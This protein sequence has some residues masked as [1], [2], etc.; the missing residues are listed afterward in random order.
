MTTTGHSDLAAL[1]TKAATGSATQPMLTGM[2]EPGGNV[3]FGE[4]RILTWNASTFN[5][6]IAFRGG[7]LSNLPVLSGPDAL[8]YKPD[9]TVAI[10][11][12]SPN[13]GAVVHWIMG[14]VIT[15]GP[16]RGEEAIEWMTSELGRRV[17]AAVFAD[18]I[19]ADIR[20][21]QGSLNTADTWVNTLDFGGSPSSGPEVS[22]EITDS[23][24]ALVF[25]SAHISAQEGESAYMSFRIDGATNP[26]VGSVSAF[27]GTPFVDG[28][29]MVVG[30][31]GIGLVED[32]PTGIHTF[33]AAYRASNLSSPFGVSFAER[34]LVVIGF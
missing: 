28:I 19:H 14:R 11:S 8:T 21:F 34:M 18:R 6:T 15:P 30:S 24:R 32:I 17:A 33:T 27:L 10:M 13:G 4:G 29:F 9:D 16:G 22:A 2:G 5:N 7:V 1:L 20:E 26:P 31:V 25:V 23:G 3:K 12:W